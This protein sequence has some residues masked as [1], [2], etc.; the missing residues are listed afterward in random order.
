M[1]AA[2]LCVPTPSF[3]LGASDAKISLTAEMAKQPPAKRAAL[4]ASIAEL[5]GH[6][7]AHSRNALRAILSAGGVTRN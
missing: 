4:D 2:S 7:G 6:F 5:L 3:D 1:H